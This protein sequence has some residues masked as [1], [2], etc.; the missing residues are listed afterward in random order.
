[1]I[2]GKMCDG[3]HNS[4][5]DEE[6]DAGV[7]EKEEVG[8]WLRVEEVGGGVVLPVALHAAHRGVHGHHRDDSQHRPIYNEQ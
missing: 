5:V 3:T 6:V 4:A 1:M 8:H 2:N 7:R